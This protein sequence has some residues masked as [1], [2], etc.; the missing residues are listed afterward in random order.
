MIE[1]RKRFFTS[2]KWREAEYWGYWFRIFGYGI[3]I[4][5]RPL[6]FSQRNGYGKPVLVLGNIKIMVLKP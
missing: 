6:L 1:Y 2:M 4:N 5:N 3:N